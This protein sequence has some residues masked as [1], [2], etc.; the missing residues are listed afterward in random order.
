MEF[1]IL[2]D[3]EF[4]SR[5][6][7]H[8]VGW[9]QARHLLAILLMRPG[10]PIPTESIIGKMWGH[11]PPPNPRGTIHVNVTRL[12]KR[13][14]AAREDVRLINRSGGYKLEIDKEAIDYHRFGTLLIQA[15]SMEESGELER[16]VQ[17]YRDATRLWR[18]EPL[19]GLPG[20]W[21][22]QTREMMEEERLAATAKRIE[23]ELQLDRNAEVIPELAELTRRHPL[24]EKFAELLMLALY[25]NGR[26]ADALAV[27]QDIR[28]RLREELGT[29]PQPAL[30]NLQVRILRAEPDLMSVAQTRDGEPPNTLPRRNETFTGRTTALEQL[31]GAPTGRT[32]PTV[33]VIEGMAGVGKTTL[34]IEAAYRL[35]DAYPHGQLYLDLHGYSKEREPLDPATALA[36]LLQPIGERTPELPRSLDERAALWRSRLAHRKVLIVLDNADGH[37]QIRP[38]L[39]GG[40]GCMVIVTSG[41]RL[42]G[43]DDVRSIR[44]DLPPPEE[45]AMLFENVVGP[46][47]ELPAD[48]VAKV[49]DLCERLPLAIQITGSKLRHRTS[50]SVADLARKMAKTYHELSEFRGEDRRLI[51]A[52]ELS[53]K[54]LDAPQQEAFRRLGLHPGMDITAES[55]AALLGLSRVDAEGRLD[56]LSDH[57][58]IAEPRVGLYRSHQLVSEY[59]RMKAQEDLRPVQIEALQRLFDFY[60]AAAWRADRLLFPHHA[61]L[62]PEPT[63]IQVTE[64]LFDDM[65]AALSWLNAE[66]DNLPAV[67]RQAATQGWR[68]QSAVLP[69]L[70]S[71]HLDAEGRWVEAGELHEYALSVWR[72]LA[73]RP[74][75]ARALADLSRIRWRLDQ[76]DE[77]LRLAAEALPL[78]RMLGDEHVVSEVLEVLG[79]VHWYRDEYDRAR[80]YI[81]Q[82]LDLRER[83]GDRRGQGAA[84]NLLAALRSR[85]GDYAEA[86]RCLRDALAIYEAEDDKRGQQTTHNNIAE[87]ELR[88]GRPESALRHYEQVGA[89]GLRLSAV[90]EAIL[91]N[92]MANAYGQLHRREEALD[93]HRRALALFRR[94]EDRRHEA[95][96]L[97]D[98]GFCL[99]Q[100]DRDDEAQIHVQAALRISVEIAARP[101]EARALRQLGT[102]HHRA[103][104]FDAAFQHFR[105]ALDIARDIGDVYEEACAQNQIGYAYFTIGDQPKAVA[106]WRHALELFTQVGVPDAATF[107]TKL[108][109][110]DNRAGA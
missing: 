35:M 27:Y 104:C 16:A 57:Y 65:D 21:A 6:Q 47:R 50:W 83:I 93:H 3:I 96:V 49:I 95:E 59:A 90:N 33:I 23:L 72:E 79:L 52:F 63:G 42:S 46:G 109:E 82:A 10:Q 19:S 71:R 77:A 101:L 61:P 86:T 31:L 107:R 4:W 78:G 12:R 75:E 110:M 67:V 62:G 20:D 100:T 18:G 81:E 73:D 91:L 9:T 70:L 89:L 102:I 5:G 51:V 98:L 34:A 15:R 68:R 25:R 69:H 94:M 36:R 76:H 14:Q 26:Q 43:L 40:P 24:H 7:L 85:K 66:G 84:L 8:P 2:G 32:G 108:S 106:H 97:N 87:A 38:L 29:E 48:D 103:G 22:N 45:A 11:D 53:Y 80:E 13:F 17:L 92:N 28:R 74:G 99:I 56:K 41:R 105:A 60:V 44:L 30:R 55:A 64:D 37:E 54:G 58:L 88:L 39:P 1:R